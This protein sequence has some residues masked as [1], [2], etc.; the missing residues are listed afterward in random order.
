MSF[1]PKFLK[2]LPA[3]LLC[4]VLIG[5]GCAS[6]SH[7]SAAYAETLH[8]AAAKRAH[9]LF[10]WKVQGERGTVYLLGTIHIGTASFYPLPEAIESAFAHA[11]ALVGE[12][13]LN[14]AD[15]DQV[16]ELTAQ[17][18]LY[19][20]HDELKNH[21]SK[22]TAAA[23]DA[24][25]KR[26]GTNPEMFKHLRP[27][28]ASMTVTVGALQKQGFDAN[29]GIDKHFMDEAAQTKKPIGQLESA[30]FQLKLLS[31][32][33]DDL[34]DKLLYSSLL[35][36]DKG[37]QYVDA[38]ANA[39]RAGDPHAMDELVGKD[40]R[41]HPELKELFQKVLYDRNQAMAEKI[42]G[43][44]NRPHTYFVVVG[45]GHLVGDRGLL[46]ILQDKGN[47]VEQLSTS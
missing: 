4:G 22:E 23:L 18:G 36:A 3:W 35:D 12:I 31:S 29:E 5:L 41:E 6:L 7:T 44:L 28:L 10:C 34:Q 38:L 43:W 15:S 42:Q 20:E 46:K 45:A 24:F 40:E 19:D 8:K 32:F 1:V 16:R 9:K 39:W 25:L 13:D 2:L 14:R 37:K 30:E 47:K 27:W 17:C 33:P 11:D 21:I 26:T